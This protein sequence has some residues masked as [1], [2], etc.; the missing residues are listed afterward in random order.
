MG[1]TKISSGPQMYGFEICTDCG[2][3]C[4][5]K[6]EGPSGLDLLQFR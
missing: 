3:E 1:R 2:K 6:G 4:A 5:G